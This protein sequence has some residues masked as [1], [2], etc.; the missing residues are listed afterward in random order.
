MSFNPCFFASALV[1]VQTVQQSRYC[2]LPFFYVIFQTHTHLFR[3]LEVLDYHTPLSSFV[4]LLSTFLSYFFVFIHKRPPAI[5]ILPAHTIFFAPVTPP[6]VTEFTCSVCFSVSSVS[7]CGYHSSSFSAWLYHILS[8]CPSIFFSASS[9]C[10]SF[11]FSACPVC[12]SIQ[13][14]TC[15]QSSLHTHSHSL[16]WPSFSL[17]NQSF[18]CPVAS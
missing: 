8:V 11:L 18:T 16:C 12:L 3:F 4:H 5:S 10:P 7:G 13:P 6:S 9:V 17:S 2:L 15:S 14:S 1:S